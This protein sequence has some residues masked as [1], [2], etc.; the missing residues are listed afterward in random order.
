[1]IVI[2]VFY[3]ESTFLCQWAEVILHSLFYHVQFTWFYIDVFDSFETE[4]HA[5]NC[6][7]INEKNAFNKFDLKIAF[8]IF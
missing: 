2:M 1:M 7:L 8:F 5:Q 4:M 6:L 3:G